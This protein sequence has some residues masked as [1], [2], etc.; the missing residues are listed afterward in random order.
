[1]RLPW[2]STR[3]YPLWPLAKTWRA[4]EKLAENVVSA[5]LSLQEGHDALK[6][7]RVAGWTVPLDYSDIHNLMREI[8]V[9]PYT[10][11]GQISFGQLVR[12][13]WTWLVVAFLL[14]L[15]SWLVIVHISKLNARLSDAHDHLE[16]KVEE[17]T[18]DLEDANKELS[19]QIR[20]RDLL[21]NDLVA[22]KESLS[23]AQE[24]SHLGNWKW[25]ILDQSIEWS[26]E[27]FR[28][29]GIEVGSIDTTYANFM[30][31]VHPEDRD[32]VSQ[33]I[34][35]S[36]NDSD[37]P[38]ALEHRIIHDDGTLR[39]VHE[40]GEVVWDA[41]GIAVQMLGTVQDVTERKKIELQLER[42]V[43]DKEILGTLLHA[44][45]RLMP[46][47]EYLETMLYLLVEQVAWLRGTSQVAVFMVDTAEQEQRLEL[48]ASIGFSR[49][50]KLECAFVPFGKCLCGKAASGR[51]IVFTSCVDEH[52][53]IRPKDLDPHGHYCVPIEKEEKLLGVLMLRLREGHQADDNEQQ[54]LK[55]VADIFSMGIARSQ[56]EG[57]IE[58]YAYHDTLT[59]LP[60]RRLL[61]DRLNQEV[62][63]AERS[64]RFGA[65]FYLD[66]DNFKN[67][68]DSLGH[69]IGDSL[70]LQVA[71]RLSSSLRK[72]DTI[73]RIGG[74]EFVILLPSL[75]TQIENAASMAGDKAEQIRL[76]LHESYLLEGHEYH[77]SVSL[78][79]TLFPKDQGTMDDYL[80]QA[81]SALY[82]AK[83]LGRDTLF[84]YHRSMQEAAIQR[85]SLE[86]DIRQGINAGQFSLHYQPQ[87]DKDGKLVGA[88]SLI[89]W[90][91]P[92]RGSVSPGAFIPIAE[93]SGLIV[94]LGRQVIDM[95]CRF[96]VSNGRRAELA[97]LSVNISPKQFNQPTFVDDI[98]NCIKRH[99]VDPG[100]L[101]LEITESVLLE[102]F[103][104][105][106]VKLEELK[107]LSIRFSIDDF[108]TG[109][110]SMAYLKNLPVDEL[111]IDQSFV[112]NVPGGASDA[113]IIEAIISMSR[114]F[115]L[116]VVAEGVETREQ[117]EFLKASGCG[118]F[119]GYH[120][121]RPLQEHD[122]VEKYF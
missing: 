9:G 30:N 26:D 99:G 75:S 92:E 5:L 42:A 84:F 112:R 50:R 85:L 41:N 24:M 62:L 25:N 119:Q 120:F 60:N 117:H 37:I 1:M 8:R 22:A 16:A 58:Y 93:E 27:V 76:L 107:S 66:L 70:L 96:L 68:N 105:V 47:Q 18:R 65:V 29:F 87:V 10:D 115:G 52:H 91:H 12:Q 101:V 21:F 32:S 79:I 114:H 97:S 33:A 69:P 3:L 28:I 34:K 31:Y 7:G 49:E 111:K 35:A 45:L 108:G 19:T 2:V 39:Y 67:L 55:R 98:K 48:A 53:D 109:Y 38:Y 104:S 103:D 36:I 90:Q 64:G 40:Q 43:A 78:G 14:F 57:E 74:D 106:M 63:Q 71:E 122:F 4:S 15:T 89:R 44:S 20:K 118:V 86:R 13:Y 77:T 82:E 46:L 95:A 61:L 121:D 6:K 88:E 113:A 100:R 102:N 72:D 116:T 110:S 17:R 59:G 73:A 11:Y 56:A 54:F 80:K 81:D 83:R 51:S 94:P 23:K